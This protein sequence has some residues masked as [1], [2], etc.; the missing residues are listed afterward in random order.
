MSKNI[1]TPILLSALQPGSLFT[2]PG[3]R[4]QPF[5]KISN[6]RYANMREF[7][8]IEVDSNLVVFSLTEYQIKKKYKISSLQLEA[9]IEHIQRRINEIY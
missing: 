5:Y 6:T 4:G 2:V 3:A 8:I 1:G 9:W 7:E